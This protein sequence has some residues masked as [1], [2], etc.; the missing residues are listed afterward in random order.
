MV[1]DA[2]LDHTDGDDVRLEVELQ[3]T[4]GQLPREVSHLSPVYGSA[5]FVGYESEVE[6]KSWEYNEH[7]YSIIYYK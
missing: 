6:I 1:V 5:H 4:N 7:M 2:G 3:L